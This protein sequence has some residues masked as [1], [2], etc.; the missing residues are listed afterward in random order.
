MKVFVAGG[1][2]YLGIGFYLVAQPLELR[3]VHFKPSSISLSRT[4]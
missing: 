4:S 1:A 3:A 2:G